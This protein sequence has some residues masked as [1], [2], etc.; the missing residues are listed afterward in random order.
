MLH[1]AR[2]N[3][4]ESGEKAGKLLS[5][6][7]KQKKFNSLIPAIQTNENSLVTDPAKINQRFKEYYKD[8]YSS[9]CT[10]TDEEI[11]AFLDLDLPKL[12]ENQKQAL[13]SPI[14]L[15]EIQK[16]IQE[17]PLGKSPGPDGFTAEFFKCYSTELSP[18][19]LDLYVEM[20]NEES[21]A[22]SLDQAIV[23]LILKPGKTP[24]ECKNYRPISL[25]QTDCKILSKILAVRL[26]KVISSLIHSDQVGFICKRNSSDNIRRL[27]NIF[28]TVRESN[29]PTAAISLDA[30]K[31][32]DRVEWQY[33]FRV[34]NRFGFGQVFMRWIKIL[35][36]NPVAAVQTNGIISSFFRLGRGT[37]QGSSLSPALFNLALE[38]LAQAIRKNSQFPGIKIGNTSHKLILYADDILCFVTDPTT[39]IPVL[40]NIINT[41]SKISGYKVN[42][43]KSEALPLTSYCPKTLFQMGQFRWPREGIQY[44]G[45][46]FP[47]KLD[48]IVEK[49]LDPL[50]KN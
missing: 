50:I 11:E 25:I 40:L 45:I 18:F 38:P 35:Y 27:I 49:N 24:I 42:W 34:L 12:D 15:G 8:L 10:T 26:D 2:Q 20:F 33:M 9:A 19:L 30:E 4:F 13:D 28:W 23:T 47:P 39:S 16:A 44:L 17:L 6:Y 32:F 1:R 37:R 5:N 22:P 31:A 7:I 14:T 36:K 41:F 43:N 46:L 29:T 21:L 48:D 3:Y